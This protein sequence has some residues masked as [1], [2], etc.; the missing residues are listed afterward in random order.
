LEYREFH[1]DLRQQTCASD[2]QASASLDIICHSSLAQRMG[3]VASIIG[4]DNSDDDDNDDNA[5]E[6]E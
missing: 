4:K 6:C 2:I 5:N 3:T 1:K